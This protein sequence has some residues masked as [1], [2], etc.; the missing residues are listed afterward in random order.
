MPERVVSPIGEEQQVHTPDEDQRGEA[1]IT[2]RQL[3]GGAAATGLA[4]ALSGKGIALAAPALQRGGTFRVGITDA[5]SNETLDPNIVQHQSDAA[6]ARNLFDTLTN[7]GPDGN[8]VYE[9]AESL[10]PNRT[11]TQWQVKLRDAEWHDGKPLTPDDVLYTFRRIKNPKTASQGRNILAAID[12]ARSKKINGNT[13][14]LVL[15]RP[16]ADLPLSFVR[17]AISIVPNGT[18]DFSHPVG[19]GPFMYSSFTPGDRSHFVKNPNYW[20]SGLP[21]VDALDLI[22]IPDATARANALLGGTVD[23]IESLPFAQAKNPGKNVRLLIAKYGT[24]LEIYMNVT[25]PPFDDPRVRLALR[26]AADREKMVASTL[27]GFGSVGNDV[28]SKGF[29][30][31][32]TRLPQRRYDPERAKSLLKAAGQENLKVS[33]P[34]ADWTPGMADGPLV[35]AQSA[36]AAG[37]QV[38]V[39]KMPGDK[40]GAIWGKAPIGGTY[41]LGSFPFLLDTF[42]TIK[43]PL[44]ITGWKRPGFD[45]TYA[46]A[47]ATLDPV[48]RRGLYFD[49]GRDLWDEGGYIVWGYGDRV[50]AYSSK[51]SGLRAN[52]VNSL[53]DWD[54]R[55]VSLAG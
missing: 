43:A 9:L 50:D 22:G 20:K 48:K 12:L 35:Y 10:E 25:K 41:E 53:G 36:K 14:L 6:R 37:I 33:I 44:N 23:A 15:S 31:Y 7:V 39:Q 16:N 24:A 27:Q 18:T 8:I 38:D 42:M 47:Q 55:R 3:L 32:N 1:T 49:L 52:L 26:L 21:Y 11:A 30:Y 34:T 29:P 45:A 54:F 19:T 4:L 17:E 2:R 40:Y 51:V 46:K 13:L 28:Q 5:Y